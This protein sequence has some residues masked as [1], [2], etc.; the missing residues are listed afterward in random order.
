MAQGTLL[1]ILASMG[2]EYFLK[3]SGHMYMYN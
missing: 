1:N 2:K 3:M